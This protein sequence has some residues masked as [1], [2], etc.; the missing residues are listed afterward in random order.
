MAQQFQP[1]KPIYL[2]VAD[3]VIQEIVS[4][5]KQAGEKL[6]SV[7]ELAVEKGVNPNTIQRVYRELDQRHITLTKRGQGTFV[8]QDHQLILQ[9]REELKVQYIAQFLEDMDA[10][11]FSKAEIIQSIKERD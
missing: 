1:D 11:G 2:Q 8:T 5:M 9:I 6:P 4:G 7:R 3:Q 10:L